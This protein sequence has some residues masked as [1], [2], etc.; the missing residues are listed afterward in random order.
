MTSPL[1]RAVSA[2]ALPPQDQASTPSSKVKGR[3]ASGKPSHLRGK[4]AAQ[5]WP[6]GRSKGGS[7]HRGA[8]KPSAHS[9]VAEL[10]KKIQLLEGDRKAFFE[11]SQWNIKKNQETISQLREETK[12]LELKLLDLLKGDEK[13]VQA[14]IHE[15]KWEKPYLK[16]RT[17]QQALEHLDH[18]LREKVKRQN[19]LR[20]QVVLR[21]RRLEELQLQHSLRLLEMAEAQNRHTEVAKTMRNLENRLEKARMKAQE[22]EHIT[23]V[24]L[25]LKAY[26][27][28]ESLNLENRLDSMEA[29]VV[30]TK[31]ELE[32]LHVVN[33]EALNAR[34]IAKNQLQYLEETLVRERKKRERYLSECKKR[35]EE[36]K[37]ENERMERKTHREHLLLQSDDTIQDS[38]HAKEEELRQRWSMYQMEVIFGK[39]K[40]ATGTAETHSLVQ[41][42]LAQGDTF[43]Q[44]ETLK[45]ENEQ[46]LV[47]LKQEKQQ[48]QRE[49]EDLKYSGEATLVSQQKLQAEAQERLKKEERRHAEAQDQLERA[50]RAMQVAKD[51]LE[52]LASKL[53]HITVVGPARGKPRQALLG[54]KRRSHEAGFPATP[55]CPRERGLP[56]P[57]S[58]TSEAPPTGEA[59]THSSES[60]P[61]L[62][63]E[64]LTP[65]GSP[66]LQRPCPVSSPASKGKKSHPVPRKPRRPICNSGA[67]RDRSPIL[68]AAETHFFRRPF[69][70]GL[71]RIL[72]V[73]KRPP[74]NFFI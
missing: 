63:G 3:E 23:S 66:R 37:L 34:D 50:L 70:N 31:H 60:L 61:H 67:A 41:R 68:P 25:Q 39:V 53:I 59:P 48:L 58:R 27:M 18:R 71:P 16:N 2:N 6:P 22:A 62:P 46:T 74:R 51:S 49:L 45:S 11:S 7:F 9:Q 24:Y 19:A 13:V 5:A 32:A 57:P 29:E 40:D 26:L 12:A 4:G 35:A 10:H 30:R 55:A 14:V 73:P 65:Q 47:R 72:T 43:A 56:H 52:H 42:F 38:L 44:L 54:P 8:G 17:V 69:H 36:K 33:Q 1:C 21:Q 15:W 28:D 64:A 20:H